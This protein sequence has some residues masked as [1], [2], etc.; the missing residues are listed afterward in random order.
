ML[1]T[2]DAWIAGG[3]SLATRKGP[4]QYERG[5]VE[6]LILTEVR[7]GRMTEQQAKEQGVQL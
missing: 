1:K 7:A 6:A 2:L 5:S 4:K 3:L